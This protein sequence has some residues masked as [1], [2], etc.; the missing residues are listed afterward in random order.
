[1]NYLCLVVKDTDF[2]LGEMDPTQR[3]K[4]NKEIVYREEDDGAFLF[5]PDSGNLKYMNPTGKETFL[6]LKEKGDLSQAI[7]HIHGQH[8]DVDLEQ[9]SKDVKTFLEQLKENGFISPQ[10]NG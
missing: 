10:D 5:D 2:A 7:A 9:A 8:P 1:M 4:I 6:I 3:Y